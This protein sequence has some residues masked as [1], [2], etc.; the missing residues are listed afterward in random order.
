MA[1]MN[2]AELLARAQ[3]LAESGD[4][5]GGAVTYA[6]LAERL[7]AQGDL[8]HCAKIYAEAEQLARRARRDDL[9]AMYLIAQGGAYARTPNGEESA[10]NA[11]GRAAS[12]ASDAGRHDL[13]LLA[14]RRDVEVRS[15]GRD[16]RGAATKLAWFIRRAQETQQTATLFWARRSRAFALVA[17]PPP[18]VPEAKA[19]LRALAEALAPGGDEAAML[20]VDVALMTAALTPDAQDLAVVAAYA[21]SGAALPSALRAAL[22]APGDLP[23][24]EA[25]LQAEGRPSE[26]VI[27]ALLVAEAHARLGAVEAAVHALLGAKAEAERRVDRT[28]GAYVALAMSVLERRLGQDRVRAALGMLTVG[29]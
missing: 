4:A 16:W 27:A 17:G 20:S 1:E 9:R 7:G 14:L 28:A 2:N 25:A 18:D 21:A 5:V 26:R 19:E 22:D 6:T 3:A 23:R 8:V 12:V 10:K 24:A 11:L 29:R 15:A 13:E